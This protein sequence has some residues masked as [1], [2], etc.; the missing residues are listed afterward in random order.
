MRF[1]LS[2][3]KNSF[4]LARLLG[5]LMIY[6][7]VKIFVWLIC[8][9]KL[10]YFH[11]GTNVTGLKSVSDS[12]H[13]LG[14]KEILQVFEILELL[15]LMRQKISPTQK[16]SSLELFFFSFSVKNAIFSRFSL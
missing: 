8:A 2:G 7:L 13:H 9:L 16:F 12:E 6:S 11:H 1:L 5:R 3:L 4:T 14:G 10:R 15:L